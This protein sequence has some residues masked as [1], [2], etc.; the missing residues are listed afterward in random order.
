MS[1]IKE[2]SFLD[3]GSNLHVMRILL[4]KT[5]RLKI[6]SFLPALTL[7]PV[8]KWAWLSKCMWQMSRKMC[9]RNSFYIFIRH[10]LIR[11]WPVL[12]MSPYFY[13]AFVILSEVGTFAK[14]GFTAGLVSAADTAKRATFNLDL[15]LTRHLTS[16]GTYKHSI[17]IH[18]LRA[19]D[20]RTFSSHLAPPSV[21]KLTKERERGS[22]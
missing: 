10:Y 15:V 4:E 7:A 11:P 21:H 18:S 14:F 17:R 3:H 5:L 22:M 20:R 16:L 19:F 6:G 9:H 12:S 13:S 8:W 1:H 2:K